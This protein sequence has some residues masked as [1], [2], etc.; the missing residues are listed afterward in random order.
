MKLTAHLPDSIFRIE[1][2]RMRNE[3]FPSKRAEYM[4]ASRFQELGLT[5]GDIGDRDTSFGAVAA[6]ELDFEPEPEVP[7][8]TVVTTSVRLPNFLVPPVSPILRWY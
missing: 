3:W 6:S 8:T 5:R 4:T 1:R 7:R 2:G